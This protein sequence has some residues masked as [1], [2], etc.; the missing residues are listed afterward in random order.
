[1]SPD[2]FAQA[3]CLGFA[4]VC[5][6]E[7]PLYALL[8]WLFTRG[9]RQLRLQAGRE[10]TVM[11]ALGLPFLGYEIV[12]IAYFG[13]LLPNTFLAKPP[14]IFGG[15]FGIGYLLQWATALGGPLLVVLWLMRR[16]PLESKVGRLFRAAAG[17]LLAAAIFV[18]YS[19]GDWMPFGRFMVPV[20]PLMAACVGTLLARWTGETV[21]QRRIAKRAIV[22][23]VAASLG[24]SAM[25]AWGT[26]L[27]AY[28]RNEG[29]NHIMRGTDQVA[30]GQWM[31]AHIRAGSTVA[32]KRL[33][34]ISFAALT[35]SSGTCSA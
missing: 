34:G 25:A 31:A 16:P 17:P 2:D 23:P 28:T 20:A 14:G 32:T 35:L 18:V 10:M 27:G 3:L 33:G 21:R 12:R 11:A 8:W 24:L 29:T 6:P 15:L 19:R 13:E 30:A 9:P 1:V 26:E 7:A 22:L 4:A 5:R